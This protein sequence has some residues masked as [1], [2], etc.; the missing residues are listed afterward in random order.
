MMPES[1]SE[2]L[3]P[4][5]SAKAFTELYTACPICRSTAL[6]DRFIVKGFTITKCK[7]CDLLFV[8]ERLTQDDLTPFY[9]MADE[10]FVYNDPVN[11]EN[12]TYYFNNVKR[13]INR[14]VEQG[15]ILDVGCST[16]LFLD[17]MDG[18][19]RH[20]IE[21]PSQAGD[22]ARS[23]YG[24][25]IHLGTLDDYECDPGYFDCITFFDSF[26]HMLH[27]TGILEQCRRLLRPGGLLVIKVHDTGCLYAKIS[28]KSLYSIVPPY[29]VF[30]YTRP[31]LENA[32]RQARFKVVDFRHMAHILLIKTIPFRLARGEKNSIFYSIFRML[33]KTSVGGLKVRK[34]LHDLMTVFAVKEE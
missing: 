31:S 6:T 1:D 30:F 20:G 22:V 25:R 15:R 7:D 21:F 32:L 34:N 17:V 3:E 27:P 9:D 2:A 4:A 26:D 14:R 23:K 18:W 29:H 24:D 11:A 10:E 33:E 16:A 19:E 13:L 5:V 12:L 8:R 28:G